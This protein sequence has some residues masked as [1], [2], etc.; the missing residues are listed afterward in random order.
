MPEL[1]GYLDHRGR[2]PFNRWLEGLSLPVQRRILRVVA[3]MEEGNFGDFRSVGEGVMERRVNFGPGYR[4]YYAWDGPML[5]ILLGGGD[6][7][8]QRNDID[9][10]KSRWRDYQNR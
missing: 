6:K 1:R 7:S 3:R 2:N 9:R 10:S 8:D 5:V 4:I